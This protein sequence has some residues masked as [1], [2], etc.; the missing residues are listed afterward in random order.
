MDNYIR[1]EHQRAVFTE[2]MESL[3]PR[4]LLTTE[5]EAVCEV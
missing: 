1:C 5:T 2:E 4:G 3:G